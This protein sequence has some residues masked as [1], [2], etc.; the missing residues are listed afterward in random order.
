MEGTTYKAMKQFA[1]SVKKRGVGKKDFNA[2]LSTKQ[3][4][5]FYK[6]SPYL[7]LSIQGN[8]E[9]VEFITY[10]V[11]GTVIDDDFFEY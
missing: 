3:D 8:G 7:I 6:E 9:Q 4:I 2:I 5:I 1:E 11:Y 10:P